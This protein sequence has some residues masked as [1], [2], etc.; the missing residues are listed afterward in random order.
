MERIRVFVKLFLGAVSGKGADDPAEPLRAAFP[1]HSWNEPLE[2]GTGSG[3]AIAGPDSMV[4]VR[5]L[6]TSAVIRAGL[7]ILLLTR[8]TEQAAHHSAG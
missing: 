6:V 8:C 7:M 5:V 4:A 3:V 1:G 2:I